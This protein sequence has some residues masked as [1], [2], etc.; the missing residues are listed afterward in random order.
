MVDVAVGGTRRLQG[1]GYETVLGHLGKLS[2]TTA[3]LRD[4]TSPTLI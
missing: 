2:L 1:G 4:L 3:S